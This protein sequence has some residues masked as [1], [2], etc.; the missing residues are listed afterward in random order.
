MHNVEST[1][2]DAAVLVHNQYQSGY[3][4]WFICE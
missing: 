4:D 1:G 2:A 3:C